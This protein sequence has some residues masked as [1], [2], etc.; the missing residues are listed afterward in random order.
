MLEYRLSQ[1]GPAFKKPI[2]LVINGTSGEVTVH[3]W[4]DKGEERVESSH[5]KLPADLANG[6]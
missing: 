4:D 3:S 2:E 5:E 1:K 6:T